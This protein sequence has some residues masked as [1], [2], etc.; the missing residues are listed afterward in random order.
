MQAQNEPSSTAYRSRIHTGAATIVWLCVMVLL[1]GIS[2][3][4]T[5][6]ALT[7]VAPIWLSAF[8]F[9]SASVCLFVFVALRG[10]L[11]FPPRADWPIVISIGLLQMT[12]FTGLGMVA[13]THVDTSRATL[14]AYTTP[15][16][17]LI[18]GWVLQKIQPTRIQ[19]IALALGMIGIGV[20]CSP[21]EMNWSTPGAVMGACFL[22]T[23]AIAWSVAILHIKSHKWQASPLQLAP[24]QMALATIPLTIAAYTIEGVPNNVE[25]NSRLLELLFFIGP[26]ATSACFVISAEHGRRISTFAMSNFT[27][28][29]PLIGITASVIFLSERLSLWFSIGLSFILAGMLMTILAASRQGRTTMKT[30]T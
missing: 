11:K 15:L 29:V 2:W 5:K 27:L 16:W 24:W 23:G 14:L 26:I 6:L 25:V 17:G 20:I 4:V 19:L 13:M 22:I 8:R 28:G 10:K 7:E 18:S 30:K 3:P 12:V 9:G 21:M 1:W